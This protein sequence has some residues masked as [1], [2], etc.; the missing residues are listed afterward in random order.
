[1]RVLKSYFFPFPIEEIKNYCRGKSGVYYIKNEITNES[2]IGSAVS[3]TELGNRIYF[4]F[5]NHF[6]HKSQSSNIN[7]HNSLK[8][9]GVQHFSFNILFIDNYTVNPVVVREKET[10]YIKKLSPVFNIL[11]E[12]I[13]SLG[14]KHTVEAKLKFKR[15]FTQARREF[16]GN[17]NMPPASPWGNRSLSEEK[18]KNPLRGNLAK[19]RF[20][21]PKL[22]KEFLDKILKNP[23]IYLRSKEVLILDPL[24]LKVLKEF[25]SL[26]AAAREFKCDYRT[27]RRFVKSGKVFKRHNIIIQYK[28]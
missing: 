5:R 9:Y 6:F 26:K 22:K 17:F 27:F 18:K 23:R 3:K 16:I 1:M 10:Y 15:G 2:Y 11:K 7:L 12:G 20:A 21:D 14:Y 25:Y 28:H 4:I 19:K 24:N 8:K 13:S